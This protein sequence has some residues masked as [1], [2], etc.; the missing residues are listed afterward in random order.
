MNIFRRIKLRNQQAEGLFLIHDGLKLQL[1]QAIWHLECTDLS[2]AQ[3]AY[4]N[5]RKN[6]AEYW[7]NEAQNALDG[8]LHF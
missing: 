2:E 8:K 7:E 3:R 5:A 4:W 6:F 1:N